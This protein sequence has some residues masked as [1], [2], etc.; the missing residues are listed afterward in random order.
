VNPA[1]R[2]TARA[3]PRRRTAL[4]AGLLFTAALS[5]PLAAQF[6]PAP[7]PPPQGTPPQLAAVGYDQ[8]LGEPLPLD[9]RF[10]DE[11]GREVALGDLLHG[12]PAVVALAYYR[13]PMLC[14]LVVDGLA[15]ALKAIPFAPG[16][17]IEVIVASFDPRE[18]P[19]LAAAEKAATLTRYGRPE[20][21]A[22]WH[23]LTG[24]PAAVR[25]LTRALGF[26]YAWDEAAG[27]FA[28]ASGIVVVT[29]EGRVGR[30]LYGIEYA[31]RDLRLA[32]V[33]ASAGRIGTLA[34]QV[35]L[36]CFHYDPKSGRYSAA[37][38][39]LVR[40]GG[41]ATVALLGG[42]VVLSRRRDRRR[43]GRA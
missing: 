28:H 8:R 43:E 42:F 2:T 33:D 29:P 14:N 32:L 7:P 17:D 30:Y 9:L 3:L 11:S 4:A 23:F 38:L 41:V 34:D 26:R 40:A 16:R 24:S 10:R 21:A 25:E 31:P 19:D 36:Y 22:G 5:S 39:Q 13:C 27:Q 6:A 15:T 1:L 12:R 35:L 20:T 37:V 18:T